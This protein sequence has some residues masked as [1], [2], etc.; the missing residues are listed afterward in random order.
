MDSLRVEETSQHHLS[1]LFSRTANETHSFQ[2]HPDNQIREA[3][4]QKKVHRSCHRILGLLQIYTAQHIP[5]IP[6]HPKICPFCL[7][8]PPFAWQQKNVCFH[9]YRSPYPCDSCS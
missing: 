6:A 1:F 5:D 8:S 9:S 3:L 2:I 7:P 4:R